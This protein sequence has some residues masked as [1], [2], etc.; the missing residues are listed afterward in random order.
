MWEKFF[1]GENFCM[2]NF[3]EVFTWHP[4]QDSDLIP[5]W[6]IL[7]K[8]PTF[9][10]YFVF[11]FKIEMIP[12]NL[13][14]MILLVRQKNMIRIYLWQAPDDLVALKPRPVWYNN[15]NNNNNSNNNNT[16]TSRGQFDKSNNYI[17]NNNHSNNSSKN[18]E[19]TTT[20]LK[21]QQQKLHLQ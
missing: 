15:G 13:D 14:S 10:K 11:Y 16:T 21:W 1:S 18:T 9:A 8:T 3:L 2:I 12:L 20:K 6:R 7:R 19:A 4:I 17:N 5:H